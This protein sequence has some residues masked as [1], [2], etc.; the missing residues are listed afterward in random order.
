MQTQ[1]IKQLQTLC[2]TRGLVGYSRLRKAD[3]IQLLTN[4][5]VP[6]DTNACFG[7]RC[8]KIICDIHDVFFPDPLRTRVP[9][10]RLSSRIKDNIAQV[11]DQHHLIVERYIGDTRSQVDFILANNQT[12]S[13]KTNLRLD[14][15]CPQVI[16]QTTRE[17]FDRRF[18][19]TGDRKQWIAD[20]LIILIPEYI[21]YT[22]CC[23]YL[24]WINQQTAECR[25][26][27]KP[28]YISTD[29]IS[30]IKL[31]RSIENWN[32]SNTIK[33]GNQTLGEFQLHQNRNCVKFR[34]NL[35]PLIKLIFR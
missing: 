24:L 20:N 18:N 19:I 4:S 35:K 17:Q 28:T 5:P 32:E 9:E 26:Y 25:I 29:W 11:F 7:R 23:D 8:E 14:K 12:L 10:T 1:T 16:G 31:T 13:V 27:P 30:G 22:F 2:R 33:V 3:L 34:F 15:V 6:T 21:K